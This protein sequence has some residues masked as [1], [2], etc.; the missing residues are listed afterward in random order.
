[1]W[2]AAVPY[3][4]R[5]FDAD[6]PAVIRQMPWNFTAHEFILKLAQR[7]QDRYSAALENYA[8]RT[9]F[10]TVHRELACLL[11]RFPQLVQ[12]N[13]NVTHRQSR[14]IFGNPN[15]CSCWRRV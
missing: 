6:I 4:F 7:C 5:N 14:D 8:N 13:G 9:P 3:N 1:M 11:Y 2:R 10:K 15:G 12:R